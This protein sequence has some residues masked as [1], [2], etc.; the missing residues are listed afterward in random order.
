[1][2]GVP[3]FDFNELYLFVQVVKAGSF[4]AAGRSLNIPKTTISRKVAQLEANLGVRLLHRTTRHLKLTEVGRI[5]Y[6]QCTRI[7]S[8][9]EEANLMVTARQNIPYGTLRVTAPSSFGT[10]VLNHWIDG[11]LIQYD[12]V[13]L[14]VILTNQYLDLLAE[15]IDVAFRGG[16]LRHSSFNTRKICNL[17]FWVC[18]S[19][20]YLDANGIPEIPS[21]LLNH[22]CIC[23]STGSAP[24]GYPWRFQQGQEW[25][26]IDISGRILVNDVAFARQTVLA[27]FGI[28]YLPGT[29]IRD[30]IEQ[31]KLVRLLSPWPM[32]EREIFM[33]YRSDRLLSSKVRAF[34]EFVEDQVPILCDWLD[35]AA[36]ISFCN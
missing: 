33:V 21:D 29:L 1:M 24:T 11:F 4:S 16:P 15:D 22:R 2:A 31:R 17:P 8:D 3:N 14:D 7:I 20:S 34:L 18:A 6:D 25:T 35:S 12:Q 23:F 27:G 32:A 13:T 26:E 5:Y 30:D 28:S 19:P 10:T 9:L 36:S